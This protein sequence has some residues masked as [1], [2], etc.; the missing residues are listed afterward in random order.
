MAFG[1]ERGQIRFVESAKDA[2]PQ[3]F[4]TAFL[5]FKPHNNAVIDLVFSAD[6]S[7][8]AS[9]CGDRSVNITEMA[10]Q[11][12][13]RQF[14]HHESSVKQVR[15]Q[16]GSHNNSIL[17]S[18]GRDGN[19]LIYDLRCGTTKAELVINETSGDI[20]TMVNEIV[21]AHRPGD[22]PRGRLPYKSVNKNWLTAAE[23]AQPVTPTGEKTREYG[24][25]SITALEF[26]PGA[27]S[28][29]LITGSEF[30]SSMKVWD[31]RSV[32]RRTELAVPITTCQPPAS[33]KSHRHAG[34]TSIAVSGDG[35]RIYATSRDNAIYA[36]STS[37]LVTGKAP[38]LS[39]RT[40]TKAKR[41]PLVT[42]H[43]GPGPLY[44]FRHPLLMVNS[45]YVKSAIRPARN[46]QAEMLAVG[47]TD[48]CAV[49][50]P[51]DERYFETAEPN[52]S[53]FWPAEQGVIRSVDYTLRSTPRGR[54][55]RRDRAL[56]RELESE[57]GL[58]MSERGTPLVEGHSR[59][60]SS[61]VWTHNGDLI[62][63]GDD[64][65]AR[66][67]RDGRM[68]IGAG[69]DTARELRRAGNAGGKRWGC[70]WADVNDKSYDDSDVEDDE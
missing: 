11:T 69:E 24:P 59:E 38:E 54:K 19:V 14:Q 20:S 61:V 56:A 47:S 30:T 63:V 18:S 46:G 62:T 7:L 1:D 22:Q 64:Y 13:V 32:P 25:I 45:F 16:P 15:W 39:S 55:A 8:L 65:L 43:E 27:H 48:Q 41:P 49:L 35:A 66:C 31:I 29:L 68:E 28:H 34:I 17:A 4:S 10:T 52:L 21:D 40:L 60:V 44:A 26:L 12:V 53:R 70:G 37:H 51:T 2:T 6:D 42:H 5:S 50:F 36:Y 9:G 58:L 23:R 33:H 57:E 3:S 67:W